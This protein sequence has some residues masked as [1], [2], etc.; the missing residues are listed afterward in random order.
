MNDV[1]WARSAASARAPTSFTSTRAAAST[2][3]PRARSAQEM[4]STSSKLAA[5]LASCSMRPRRLAWYRPAGDSAQ[6]YFLQ[7]ASNAAKLTTISLRASASSGSASSG[8][9]PL[10]PALARALTSSRAKLHTTSRSAASIPTRSISRIKR[11]ALVGSKA[12]LIRARTSAT[13]GTSSRP[14]KPTTSTGIPRSIRAATMGVNWLRVR[15]STAMDLLGDQRWARN[16]AISSASARPSCTLA[17]HTL[18]RSSPTPGR[19][20]SFSTFT[21]PLARSGSLIRLAACKICGSLRQAVDSCSTGP[22]PL[23]K[24]RW[25]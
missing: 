5:A 17:A 19:L 3:N 9:A 1:A 22:L 2:S 24:W 8:S 11:S 21:W 20:T 7:K 6:A 13:S 16:L 25:N 12:T 15:H 4:K 23:L 14:P 10:D 18:P